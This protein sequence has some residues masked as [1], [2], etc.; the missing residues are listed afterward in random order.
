MEKAKNVIEKASI[1]AER[2]EATYKEKYTEANYT[3]EVSKKCD[4]IIHSDLKKAFSALV[5]F[6][7]TITEQPEAKLFSLANIDLEPTEDIQTEISKYVVTGY[8]N[9]GSEESAGVTIIGQKILKSGQVLNLIAPFTKFSNDGLDGYKYGSELELAIQ[10]CDYEVSEYLFGEKY[11]I[12]Q[13]TLDFESDAPI[14]ASVDGAA[15]NK[16]KK[17]RNKKARVIEEVHI[18]DKTA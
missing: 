15:E 6:L 11:G 10:C 3:N 17:S 13:E 5:P 9:G 18:F 4:Q 14:E 12:K 8:S 1:K 2:C 7:V 16:P